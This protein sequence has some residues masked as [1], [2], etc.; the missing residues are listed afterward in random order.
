[1]RSWG[2]DKG[3]KVE[4]LWIYLPCERASNAGEVTAYYFGMGLEMRR[5][6]RIS[7]LRIAV[8]L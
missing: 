1:M 8:E 7:E 2:N 6:D 4:Q 5:V 3:I